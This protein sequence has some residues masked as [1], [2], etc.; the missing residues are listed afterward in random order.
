M[1]PQNTEGIFMHDLPSWL[2]IDAVRYAL[3]R[4]STQ[5]STTCQWLIANWHRLPADAQEIIER[6]LGAE[7]DRDNRARDQGHECL[8]LGDDC[9]RLEWAR[10]WNHIRAEE[11]I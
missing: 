9:D 11:E 5:V 10:V 4:R 1:E 2:F 3:G 6:D 7:L 8:P